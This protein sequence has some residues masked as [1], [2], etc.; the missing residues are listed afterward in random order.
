MRL[1]LLGTTTRVEAPFIVVKIGEYT[2]G[3]YNK[4]GNG[5][6]TDYPNYMQSLSVTKIN[7]TLNQYTL[8]LRYS[9]RDG[10]DPNLF[11]KV[12]S[13]VKD[14][15]DISF[16]YGDASLPSFYF[17][18]EKALITDIKTNF[19]L[20]SSSITYTIS[21]ISQALQLTAGNFD[22]PAIVSKPSDVIIDILYN[23]S[24]GLQ[25]VFTG[26]FDKDKV[27]SKGLI[28]SDDIAVALE[29]KTNITIFNYLNYLVSC[30]RSA[31]DSNN[32]NL[33]NNLYVLTII[34]DTSGE[35][36]GTYFRVNRV[37]NAIKEINSLDTYE[38]N[39]GYMDKSIVT[40]FSI[41]NN[42]TY[43]ILYNFSEKIKQP[44][45][46]YRIDDDGNV[47]TSYS[48]NITKSGVLYK[49]TEAEKNWWSKVT[50]YPISA[51]LTLK[52]LLKPA[53][54]MTY[55]K[56][57]VLFYGRKHISSGYYIIT[58]QVDTIDP[59]GFRTVLSLTRIRGDD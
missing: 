53:I 39:I 18:E 4:N 16:Q 7:G 48:P 52:G 30:M 44:S 56:L 17:K 36:G 34:D 8:S 3:L 49:T 45:Y 33:K 24:Y 15:R 58:K 10:D 2:F 26:M 57:N 38:V 41:D 13:S 25:E 19:D 55:V 46:I 40:G 12:F 1:D 32:L 22:F 42:E 37:T 23:K 28:A 43:S 14:T 59:S 31:S 35:W 9:I 29:T 6:V 5:V 20:Q 51:T 54:L 47:K 50:Q 21:A 27:I 11:E